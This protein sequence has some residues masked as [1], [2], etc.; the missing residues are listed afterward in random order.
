MQ[1]DE[2]IEWL[3]GN[4]LEVNDDHWLSMILHEGF[5]GYRNFTDEELHQEIEERSQ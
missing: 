3:I 5:K 4:D 1:R 2:M